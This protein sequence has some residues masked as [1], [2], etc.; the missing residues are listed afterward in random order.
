MF[1]L[2][3]DSDPFNRW[4]A[5]QRLAVGTILK[6]VGDYRE[7]RA[8]K[9]SGEFTAAFAG[10]LADTGLDKSFVA[11]AL[12]LP[13]EDYLAEL[14]DVVDV[15][16][17]YAARE[18]VRKEMAVAMREMFL[19][20]YQTAADNG[21]YRVGAESTGRR[22]LKNLCLSYLLALNDQA[23]IDLGVSQFSRSDNMTDIIGALAPLTRT[24]CPER[25]EVLAA[26]YDKW[27]NDSLVL[28]K[29]FTLQATSPLPGIL[30]EVQSLLNHPAFDIRNPNRVR[31]LI[32]AFCQSNQLRFH[33]ESGA[34]Y[35]F[36]GDQVA[37]LHCLN[38]QV[39]ARLLGA[40]SNWQRFDG[41]RQALM[42]EQLERILHLPDLAKDVYE[43][44]IKSLKS[45]ASAG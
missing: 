28:D 30:A 8:L 20:T 12:T 35:R 11:E 19:D 27:Q 9:I 10:V 4:E 14:M 29:W 42:K 38:P 43:I 2:E 5:G 33:D 22:S 18:F 6:L 24:D 44:A 41:G 23:V 25:I 32:G 15:T 39:A 17:I 1:L 45:E 7:G 37:R 31:A 26:F 40:L 36:L 16:A 3:H 13:G 34:G 21:P